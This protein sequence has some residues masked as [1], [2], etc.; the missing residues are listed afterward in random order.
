MMVAAPGEEHILTRTDARELDKVERELTFRSV[1]ECHLK[2][3][4]PATTYWMVS[5]GFVEFDL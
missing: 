4:D 2:A 5:G 1:A 3:V